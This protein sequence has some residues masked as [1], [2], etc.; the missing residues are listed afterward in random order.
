M[1]KT[2]LIS[3]IVLVLSISTIPAHSE[4]ITPS[5]QLASTSL[6]KL[7]KF[8]N[9]NIDLVGTGSLGF[10]TPTERL[11]TS[12]PINAALIGVDFSDLP[13]KTANPKI[14]YEYITKPITKWYS[15]LSSG[16]MK[17]NWSFNTKYV[18]M[19][20]KLSF[21]NIGGSS[22]GTGKNTVRADEFIKQA[23]ALANKNFDFRNIDLIVV[24]PPPNTSGDQV[25]NGGAYPMITGDGYK[26]SGGEI[27]NATIINVQEISSRMYG[28]WFG[29]LGLAHELGHLTGLTDLY[30]TSWNI[31]KDKYEDQFKYMGIFSYMNY[32]G[33]DGNSIVPTAWEQWQV[34]WMKDNQFRCVKN[35]V[36]STHEISNLESTGTG[37][38]GVVV[39]VSQT[40]AIIIESRR[41]IG[42]DAT[43]PLSAEG[44]LVYTVDTLISSGNGPMKVVPKKS[45]KKTLL[46][47]APLQSGDSVVVLGYRIK[48]L[49]MKK[50]SDVIS[51][52]KLD[53]K[54]SNVPNPSTKE[55]FP[56]A[57]GNSNSNSQGTSP[58]NTSAPLANQSLGGYGTSQTE[59]YVE[60]IATGFE[61]YRLQ[62]FTLGTGTEVWNSG[63]V[64]FNLKSSKIPVANLACPNRYQIKMT[65]FSKTNG[66]GESKSTTNDGM[67]APIN[68]S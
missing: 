50:S 66:Q 35:L 46:Q 68:C 3:L 64:N 39:P 31:S 12:K 26:Y 7:S 38:K 28:P 33:A 47:D 1:K 49:S 58:S 43:M 52:S 37:V 59:G 65:I 6:C 67:L 14:D 34:G 54:P 27:L 63:I 29:A 21:Y 24:A 41:K 19:S 30:D 55:R 8:D 4:S 15:D 9:P 32:A 10:P 56:S 36:N 23:V 44:A 25:T 22:A 5:S 2:A 16:K 40:K 60:Y 53:G 13:S 45:S 42:Y 48:N 62:I 11:N 61:S 51:I 17:F 57:Q 18:R 20:Q